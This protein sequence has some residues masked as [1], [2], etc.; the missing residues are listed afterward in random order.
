MTKHFQCKSEKSA[1]SKLIDSHHPHENC[2]FIWF[3]FCEILAENQKVNQ[4]EKAKRLKRAENSNQALENQKLALAN[5]IP[6]KD[7]AD[8]RDVKFEIRSVDFAGLS[9]I[10]RFKIH[11]FFKL[12]T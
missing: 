12:S 8:G 9:F 3:F 4:Q 2:L 10:P 1:K 6:R 7:S 11:L 5:G